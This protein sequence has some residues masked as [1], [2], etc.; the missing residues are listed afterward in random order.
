MPLREPLVRQPG[1]LEECVSAADKKIHTSLGR[2]ILKLPV[3]YFSHMVDSFRSYGKFYSQRHQTM[4]FSLRKTQ[5]KTA[6]RATFLNYT[7]WH[8]KLPGECVRLAVGLGRDS[9]DI[10]H[11]E[12]SEGLGKYFYRQSIPAIQWESAWVTRLQRVSCMWRSKV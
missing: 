9:I 12:R 6:M 4:V 5:E 7:I 1:R 10:R 2:R 11:L 3:S 8:S